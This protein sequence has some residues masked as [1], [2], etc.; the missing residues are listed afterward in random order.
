MKI[1]ISLL[2]F[3]ALAFPVF[4]DDRIKAA[5]EYL[6]TG[7]GLSNI[8]E[9]GWIEWKHIGA[10]GNVIADGI[11]YNNLSDSGELDVLDCFLRAT[12]CPTTFWLRLVDSTST[13]SV[14]DTS[15]LADAVG[16]GEPSTNGYASQEIAR[17]AVGWTNLGLDAG[18][19]Q[20]TSAAKT[21]S[22]SGGSWGPVHCAILTNAQTGTTGKVFS[23]IALSTGRTL[24]DG[25]SLQ[26]IYRIKLQ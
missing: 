10:E 15:T 24:N 23:Y 18:D 20:A 9:I 26:V 14:V 1:F 2:L 8:R 3:L 16:F 17:S 12:T 22:A 11:A 6:E 4:A 21:F 25:E 7:V 19:G 5:Q 13:C